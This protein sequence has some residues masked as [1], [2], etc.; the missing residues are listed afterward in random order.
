MFD[1]S[2]IFV[3][4][5]GVDVDNAAKIWAFD[6]SQF[7][8][9][10]K[11]LK[12]QVADPVD[13]GTHAVQEESQNDASVVDQPMKVTRPQGRYKKREKGKIMHA[14]SE[15]DLEGILGKSK[16]ASLQTDPVED[17]EPVFIEIP[18]ICEE[19]LKDEEKLAEWWGHKYGFVSGGFLGA[20][21][22]IRKSG[23]SKESQSPS[24]NTRK[25]FAEE[26]QENLYKL[27]QDKATSGKKG[28]GTKDQPKKVAGCYWKGKKTRLGDSDGEISTDSDCSTKRKRSEDSDTEMYPEPKTKLKKLC[29]QLLSQAPSQTLKLKKLRRLVEAHSGTVFANFSSKHEALSYLKQKLESSRS[30]HLEGKKVSLVEGN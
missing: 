30:F 24:T 20:Q 10:L 29:K 19:G 11:R 23:S 15:K 1:L 21:S 14:Y 7:D 27:V 6:T 5:R 26:D 16:E 18:T 3:Y 25:A 28:L 2:V 8:N 22:R 4:G 13:K 17:C 12:V 9:I